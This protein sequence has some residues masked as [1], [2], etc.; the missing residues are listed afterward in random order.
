M[1]VATLSG[2]VGIRKPTRKINTYNNDQDNLIP[3]VPNYYATSN[4]INGDV[5]GLVVTSHEG[6][7]TK[8]D[9]NPRH[10]NNR[11]KSNA[12]I[13]AE[14]HQ[15]YDPDRLKLNSIDN[16]TSTF[17]NIVK[18]IHSIK[19]DESLA[20]VLPNTFSLLNN[21]LLKKIKS[22]FKKSNIYFIDPI[23]SDNQ[24]SSLREATNKQVF[25]DFDFSKQS[26]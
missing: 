9:G 23:N 22:R 24:K 11:G 25:Y 5:N 19:K 14:I 21:H 3:G 15:L 8:I 10:P 6:R 13:Q 16:S 18:Q 2:C 1:T 17:K 12:F 20:I 7:P 26:S 4:E